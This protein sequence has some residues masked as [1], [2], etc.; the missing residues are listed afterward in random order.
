M[1]YYCKM[2]LFKK[3]EKSFLGIDIGASAVKMAQLELKDGRHTLKNYAICPLDKSLEEQ[4][5]Q[6]GTRFALGAV[7]E[8]AGVIKHTI[9]E[10]KID[11]S[12]AYFSIP[13]YSSFSVLMNFPA[14]MPEQEIAAA[15]PF[16][17]K[18]YVP[19]PASEVVLGWAVIK[20]M[21]RESQDQQVLLIAVPKL[22][23]EQYNKISRLSGVAV[24]AVEEE[25]FSLSR[26]LV[27][28]DVSPIILVDMGARSL[29]LGIVD[30]GF[31]RVTHNLE[32]G[33]NRITELVAHQMG[34]S[35]R[36]AEERKKA[37]DSSGRVR[38]MLLPILSSAAA[39]VKKVIDS[40]QQKYGRKVEKMIL[41]G[42][43]I[44]LVGLKDTLKISTGIDVSFGNPFA[45]IAYPPALKPALE[46][47]GPSLAVAIGLAI[48][49]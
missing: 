33:G 35:W 37:P 12:E 1:L 27:G 44:K 11:S 25:T 10:A 29:N 2:F 45:R 9:S 5:T 43:G 6:I 46:Q 48:R 21:T 7:E 23:I 32:I 18:K 30:G 3:K 28:N 22:V 42:D 17:A 26:V 34:L 36:E 20:A 4:V 38:E 24:E 49:D 41:V 8:I 15:I 39:Q 40:Y 31:V 47:V 14:A 16:E 19:V 13:L